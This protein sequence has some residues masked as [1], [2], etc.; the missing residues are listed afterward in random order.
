MYIQ[1]E[2]GASGFVA[3]SLV[4]GLIGFYVL[5]RAVWLILRAFLKYPKN[6]HL[7]TAAAV[8]VGSVLIAFLTHWVF[9]YSYVFS[10]FGIAWLL[11]ACKA[12]EMRE[13]DT[14][15]PQ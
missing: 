1:R 9:E 11:I 10:M 12:V 6:K 5:C 7:W 3:L 4:V 2:S 8:C 15:L 14:L 13:S